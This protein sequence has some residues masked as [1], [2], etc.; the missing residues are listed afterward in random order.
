M[1]LT[2]IKIAFLGV[3]LSGCKATYK[4]V[5]ME[6]GFSQYIGKEYIL[7]S[8]MDFSG[9]NA[10][11]GYSDEISCYVISSRDPGWSGPEVITRETLTK[12]SV[13]TIRKVMECINCLE[14]S[15]SRHA[16]VSLNR[17]AYELKIKIHFHEIESGKHVERLQ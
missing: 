15:P 7:K 3:A 13:F 11:P 2:F 8:D 10:P 9:V 14:F 4:D 5:S 1:R 17:K 6:E 12:G 16:I